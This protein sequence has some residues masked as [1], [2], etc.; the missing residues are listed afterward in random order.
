MKTISFLARVRTSTKPSP[1]SAFTLIELL[2]V[3]A[4]ISLLAAILFPVFGRACENA[5]RS[6]CLSNLKQIGM[7]VMQY[8][9]D[10]DEHY[11]ATHW[12]LDGNPLGYQTRADER[13]W[14]YNLQPYLKSTQVFQCPSEKTP[15][16]APS[17]ISDTTGQT[18]T[19]YTDYVYNRLMGQISATNSAGVSASVLAGAS[20]TVMLCEYNGTAS[21]YSL[22]GGG[23]T[24][25][26]NR[27]FLPPDASGV[28]PG[29][30]HLEG[31]NLLFAD[32][33]AKWFKSATDQILD[34]VYNQNVKPTGSNATFALN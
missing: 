4:I 11:L 10:Y 32:A 27:A 26:E 15:P 29:L 34:N 20:N 6:S 33:H 23:L 31:I 17:A 7:G 1:R 28:G 24:P 16:L 18:S 22:S 8:V 13:G 3:I 2:V 21:G 19:G 9:Q 25:P 12:E 5:R 14:S 30:R